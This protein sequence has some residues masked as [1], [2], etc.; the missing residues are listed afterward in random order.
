M[1]I[2]KMSEVTIDAG[3]QTVSVLDAMDGI[4]VIKRNSGDVGSICL[5]VRR[6]GEPF[7]GHMLAFFELLFPL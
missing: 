4:E 7:W 2:L 3:S 5:V 1:V 6:P